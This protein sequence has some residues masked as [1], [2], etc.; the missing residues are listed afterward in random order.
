MSSRHTPCRSAGLVNT[1]LVCTGPPT[2]PSATALAPDSVE[3]HLHADPLRILDHHA[4]VVQAFVSVVEGERAVSLGLEQLVERR[5]LDRVD[6]STRPHMRVVVAEMLDVDE[7]IELRNSFGVR[8]LTPRTFSK[9][10]IALSRSRT[11]IPAWKNVE[12]VMSH[13]TPRPA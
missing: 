7:A 4:E 9:R 8:N 13:S 1:T 12:I 10:G 6:S 2:L 3:P 5:A 11:R